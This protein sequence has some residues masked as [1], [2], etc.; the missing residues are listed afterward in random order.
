[1]K[2]GTIR[3]LTQWYPTPCPGLTLEQ[4]QERLER[5]EFADSIVWE[6][7]DYDDSNATSISVREFKVTGRM[8]P[9]RCSD[10]TDARRLA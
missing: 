5:L 6:L 8:P 9:P 7:F 2:S 1:V 10:A 3:N 4:V